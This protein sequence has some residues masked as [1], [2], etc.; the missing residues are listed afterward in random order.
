[1]VDPV[2]ICDRTL[3]LVGDGEAL[4]TATVGTSSLTRF[5][6]SRIHQN[7]TEDVAVVGLTLAHE[8]R[9]AR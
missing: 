2:D 3:A 4:V 1:M 9:L 7:V 6:N 5:A 8:G